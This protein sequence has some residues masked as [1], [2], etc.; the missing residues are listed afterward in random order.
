[1]ID[2]NRRRD[3]VQEYLDAVRAETTEHRL[4]VRLHERELAVLNRA[5]AEVIVPSKATGEDAAWT[6]DDELNLA[7]RIHIRD[8][9][10]QH[11]AADEQAPTVLAQPSGSTSIT[12]SI[13]LDQADFET[14]SLLAQSSSLSSEIGHLVRTAL[15]EQRRTWQMLSQVTPTPEMIEVPAAEPAPVPAWLQAPPTPEPPHTIEQALLTQHGEQAVKSWRELLAQVGASLPD[16]QLPNFPTARA[17]DLDHDRDAAAL[18]ELCER[19]GCCTEALDWLRDHKHDSLSAYELASW[20]WLSVFAMNLALTWRNPVLARRVVRAVHEIAVGHLVDPLDGR[21][22]YGTA[23]Q[24]ALDQVAAWV[25]PADAA[26]SSALSTALASLDAAGPGHDLPSVIVR[27]VV[28][29]ACDVATT[30]PAGYV[31]ADL[32]DLVGDL[33]ETVNE[34]WA[35]DVVARHLPYPVLASAARDAL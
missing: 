22:S 34:T 13:E 9:R 15:A 28:R 4:A 16:C 11:R 26:C 27:G 12:T 35:R 30:A 20:D 7:I 32:A 29:L 3:A 23:E 1:M 14:L 33:N 25:A 18:L 6:L 10:R 8:L 17:F 21:P 19:I 5:V 31:Q 24:Q 2:Q